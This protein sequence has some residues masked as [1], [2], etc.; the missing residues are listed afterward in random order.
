[1]NKNHLVYLCIVVALI[2]II[3]YFLYY[4][5]TLLYRQQTVL[6]GTDKFDIKEIYPTKEGGREWFI[7]MDNPKKDS[8]FSI[9]NDI[10]LVK[11]TGDGSWSVNNSMI[12]MNVI[13]TKGYSP[14]KNI[15]MTGYVKVISSSPLINQNKSSNSK[16]NK[17]NNRDS[18]SEESSNIVDVD[19]RAR[20][21]VHNS[22]NPCKGTALNGGIYSDGTV[23]WKKEIW[24]TGG[25][26][27]ARG[28]NKVT[29]SLYDRWIGWKVVM[30]N[31]QNNKAVKMESYLDNKNNNQWLKVADLIDNGGWYA[32]SPNALFYSAGC[33]KPKDY[34]ITNGGPIATFRADNAELNFKNLSI[35]E[36]QTP[37]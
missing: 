15:E 16:D 24:H 19:W 7:D 34:I 1:L 36:I 33:D 2:S 6:K 18:D 11:N 31:I 21:G 14:W 12:R 30:Y 26:T 5:T 27:D 3:V 37:S 32:N 13:T 10:P 9:T 28:T 17:N 4:N 35:R 25:Y 23:T 20:G 22:K 8:L 29:N